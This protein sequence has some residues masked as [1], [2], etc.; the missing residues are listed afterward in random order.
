MRRLTATTLGHDHPSLSPDG[1][2]LA[3]TTVGDDYDLVSLPVDGSAPGKLTPNSR[4]ALSLSCSASEA[5]NFTPG[6]A[7]RRLGK[8][9][10]LRR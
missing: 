4:N 7:D 2:R 8:A 10:L 9:W 5:W 1:T 3:F 6:L